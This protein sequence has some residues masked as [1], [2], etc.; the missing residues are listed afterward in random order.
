ML[1]NHPWKGPQ[2]LAS[3]LPMH[4]PHVDADPCPMNLD[5]AVTFLNRYRG[6]QTYKPTNAHMHIHKQAFLPP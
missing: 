1:R 4:L 6:P 3:I 2:H 5:N